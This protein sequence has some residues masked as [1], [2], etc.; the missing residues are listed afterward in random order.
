MLQHLF[1][2]KFTQSLRDMKDGSEAKR[3]RQLLEAASV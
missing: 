2:Y 1:K 3:Y